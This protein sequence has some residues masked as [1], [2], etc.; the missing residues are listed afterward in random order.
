M[1]RF[2]TAATVTRRG[3][4][5]SLELVEGEEKDQRNKRE[6]GRERERNTL[7]DEEK[8]EESDVL[9]FPLSLFLSLS[10]GDEPSYFRVPNFFP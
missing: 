1:P 10:P 7:A 4:E 2:R 8:G 9:L 6:G 3:E 5:F